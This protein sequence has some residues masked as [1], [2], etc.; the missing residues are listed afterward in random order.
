MGQLS[1]SIG[2]YIKPISLI[3]L[4]LSLS[5]EHIENLLQCHRKTSTLGV[6]L[7][8]HNL[9]AWSFYLLYL[10]HSLFFLLT[11]LL[12]TFLELV[13]QCH[14]CMYILMW[15]YVQ[16]SPCVC[17]HTHAPG[18]YLCVSGFTLIS[19]CVSKKM[20]IWVR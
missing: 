18:L 6:I 3:N 7:L 20:H 13:Y 10:L 17:M 12:C 15:E 1:S 5:L 4:L 19:C 14:G 2:L 9:P 11:K 8:F 16:A